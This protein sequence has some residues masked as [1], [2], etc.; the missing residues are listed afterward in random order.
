MAE[1]IH[2]S[3]KISQRRIPHVRSLFLNLTEQQKIILEREKLRAEQQELLKKHSE[4]NKRKSNGKNV[5]FSLSRSEVINSTNSFSY[6]H[7]KNSHDFRSEIKESTGPLKYIKIVQFKLKKPI[8]EAHLKASNHLAFNPG[9]LPSKIK[10]STKNK[11]H[12]LNDR[13]DSSKTFKIAE[14]FNRK[15]T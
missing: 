5:S 11:I 6:S 14:L 4:F 9:E 13:F 2:L 7:Q 12:S 3:V 8:N 15:K 10:I 1:N